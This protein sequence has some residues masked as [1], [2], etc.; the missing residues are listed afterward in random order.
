MLY[1]LL[2]LVHVL[3]AI[4]FV[5]NITVGI[6]W[7]S[8]ADSTHD[9]RIIA[10]TIST[11]MAA[12][13]VFTIP[14][15]IFILI[16]GF[17]AAGVGHINVL[18]TGWMLWGLGLFIIA[19][20]CFGPVARAQRALHAVAQAGVNSGTMDWARYQQI[21][22]QWN[23]FG[24]IATVAPILAVVVMVLKPVLPAL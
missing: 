14:G 11:I 1:L 24:T 19:G 5:G 15:A 13:R 20:V 8:R 18:T 4:M 3:G 12:D 2:K 10:Q 22:G 23:I 9:P 17:G 21:S 6:L 7:K 16:G